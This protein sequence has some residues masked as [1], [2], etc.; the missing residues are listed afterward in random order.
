MLP[1]LN[2]AVL[3]ALARVGAAPAS[4]NTRALS[5]AA[6]RNATPPS[7]TIDTTATPGAAA[8]TPSTPKITAPAPSAVKSVAHGCASASRPPT[9]IPAS[10][11]NP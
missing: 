8:K 9:V 4:W 1:T 6:T 10:A 3:A 5:G 7:S 11:A 2:A